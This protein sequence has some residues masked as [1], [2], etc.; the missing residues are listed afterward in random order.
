MKGMG[1]IEYKAVLGVHFCPRHRFFTKYPR[2]QNGV[3][4]V[5]VREKATKIFLISNS[6]NEALAEIK[7]ATGWAISAD[8]LY[9]WAKQ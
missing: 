8:L 5:T 7:K 3:Y 2:G 1:G 9:K 4:N 6:V